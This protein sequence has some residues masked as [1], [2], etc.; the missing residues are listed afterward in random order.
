[1]TF[2]T[3]FRRVFFGSALGLVLGLALSLSRPVAAQSGPYSAQIQRAIASLLAGNAG[4]FTVAKLA[5][6]TAA[7]PSLTFASDTTTGIFKNAA[8]DVGI[9]TGGTLRFDVS[10][11]AVTSTLP[12]VSAG[13]ITAG[14]SSTIGW[15]G[16]G[17]ISSPAD[18]VFK[19]QDNANNNAFRV[20]GA[21][22]ATAWFQSAGGLD[23]AV[24]RTNVFN[25]TGASNAYQIGG[26][27]YIAGAAPTVSAGFGST[28]QG[29]IT[30]NTGTLVVELTVGTNAG[31]TTG[32][33]TF[34]S[35][36]HGWACTLQD[37]TNTA[38]LTRQSGFTQTTAV[39]TTTVA[40]TT[41]DILVGLCG[42]F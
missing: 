13:A 22:S 27:F 37:T 11:T 16:L 2:L 33:I 14:A 18:G 30:N 1:M 4:T 36:P 8:N 23:S 9:A 7:A 42:P 20:S 40:W 26:A 12:I 41:G 24:V 31:G 35:A 39:F 21:L 34:P 15:T 29:S 10:S 5:D 38:D 25:S 6:G 17:L 32:T 28:S 3:R 19:F